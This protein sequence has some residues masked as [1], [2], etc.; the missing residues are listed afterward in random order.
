MDRME[1][2]GVPGST[3]VAATTYELLR[4]RFLFEERGTIEVKGKGLM[5]TYLLSPV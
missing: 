2:H 3:H 1:S 5:K 4:D